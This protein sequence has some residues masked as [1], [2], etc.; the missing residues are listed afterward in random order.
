VDTDDR[1]LDISLG[2]ALENL[3]IATRQQGREPE[4]ECFPPNAPESLVVHL[5]RRGRPLD[6][7][8]SRAIP[9]RQSTRSTYDARAIPPAE[10]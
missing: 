2:A 1:A 6:A 3:R 8:W 4:T 7:D 10:L 5:T 9:E